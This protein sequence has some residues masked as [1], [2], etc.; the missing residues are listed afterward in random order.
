MLNKNLYRYKGKIYSK[1]K[2]YSEDKVPLKIQ[3]KEYQSTLFS[4][5]QGELKSGLVRDA[6][7]RIRKE[8]DVLNQRA[9]K[10]ESKVLK[11]KIT[12]VETSE[13]VKKKYKGKTKWSIKKT[14][15]YYN[16]KGQKVTKREFDTYLKKLQKAGEP[17]NTRTVYNQSIIN[18][19]IQF[20]KEGKKV[21]IKNGGKKTVLNKE[22]LAQFIKDTKNM[23]GEF[24]KQ[25]R[26]KQIPYEYV[27]FTANLYG[28]N[29]AEID[30]S[31]TE[32]ERVEGIDYDHDFDDKNEYQTKFNFKQFYK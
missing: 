13:R 20:L 9:T 18:Q 14:Y 25:S 30:L 8:K 2:Q 10:K 4:E 23:L 28:E 15:D 3:A 5:K 32:S 7:G 1:L 11:D 17:T 31:K 26:E 29:Y 6:K 24:Y 19:A 21:V 22:N 12:L 16:S 27:I